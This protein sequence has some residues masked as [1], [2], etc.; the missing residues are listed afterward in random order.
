MVSSS[1]STRTSLFDDVVHGEEW[2]DEQLL[3]VAQALGGVTSQ[4]DKAQIGATLFG[5]NW[6][7][8]LKLTEQ[9]V[10]QLADEY[11][12]FGQNLMIQTLHA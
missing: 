1:L 2:V 10:K 3:T 4:A 9:N 5:D 8:A 11:E 6:L 12:Q 7:P